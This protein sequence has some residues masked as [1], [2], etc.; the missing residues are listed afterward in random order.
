M[1]WSIRASQMLAHMSHLKDKTKNIDKMDS[2]NYVDFMSYYTKALHNQEHAEIR[3]L[4]FM[5]PSKWCWVVWQNMFEAFEC[6][7]YEFWT[8]I[9]EFDTSITENNPHFQAL[10]N[11][12][13]ASPPLCVIMPQQTRICYMRVNRPEVR[14][15]LNCCCLFPISAWWECLLRIC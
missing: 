15:Q 4:C 3:Q 1:M 10:A 6:F 7:M 14:L 11:Q 9:T 12:T 8:N 13:Y 5:M 2:V